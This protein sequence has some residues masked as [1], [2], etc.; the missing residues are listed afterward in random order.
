MSEAGSD[1]AEFISDPFGLTV[2]HRLAGYLPPEL[3]RPVGRCVMIAQLCD[4]N[5]AEGKRPL[6][7]EIT[8]TDSGQDTKDYTN[9]EKC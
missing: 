7:F 2:S 9:S 6:S 3:Q 8:T 4:L 5:A 1:R